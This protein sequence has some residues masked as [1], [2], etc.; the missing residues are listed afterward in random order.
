MAGKLVK[1]SQYIVFILLCFFLNSC[2]ALLNSNS[3]DLSSIRKE[4]RIIKRNQ[5]KLKEKVELQEKIIRELKSEQTAENKEQLKEEVAAVKKT[6]YTEPIILYKAGRSALIEEKYTAAIKLFNDFL[7]KFPRNDL[8]DNALYWIG[9]CY[10]ATADFKKAIGS[11]KKVVDKY[12]R[13][14]KVPDALLKTA[15]SYFS[16]NDKNRAH[17]YLKLVVEKYPFSE[18]SEKAQIKLKAFQ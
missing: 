1:I 13:G 18:A 3:S 7:T 6:A 4:L 10:Y 17:H 5:N 14:M 15:Y 11:F 9:E 16:L 2:T 8:A 12:P